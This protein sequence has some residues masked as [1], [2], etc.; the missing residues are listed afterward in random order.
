MRLLF[1]TMSYKIGVLEVSYTKQNVGQ[2]W[3]EVSYKTVNV[4]H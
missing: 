4:G 2:K 1:Y 3:V